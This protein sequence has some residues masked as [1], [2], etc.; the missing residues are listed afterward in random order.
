MF[1]PSP[2]GSR[3]PAA[4]LLMVHAKQ[5][6]QSVEHQNRDLF[7]DRM[8]VRAR[9]LGGSACRNRDVAKRPP[10]I[11]GIPGGKRENVGGVVFTEERSIQTGQFGIGC[12]Q[13]TELTAAGHGLPQTSGKIP[14]PGSIQFLGDTAE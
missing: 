9:L 7:F 10:G 4:V 6:Q 3:H 1:L 11:P 8:A 5:M 13:T 14:N 2:F 12:D